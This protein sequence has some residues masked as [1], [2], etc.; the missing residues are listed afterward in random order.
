MR[1]LVKYW[2]GWIDPRIIIEEPDAWR[3]AWL[4]TALES[5]TNNLELVVFKIPK[6]RPG[7]SADPEAVR[8]I[9]KYLQ[10][11]FGGPENP[12]TSNPSGPS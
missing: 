4:Q 8:F 12:I 10:D 9:E 3:R 2:A 1:L 7:T 5:Q 11:R 6:D